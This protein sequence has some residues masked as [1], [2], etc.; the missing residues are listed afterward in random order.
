[1]LSKKE[2]KRRQFLAMT[3]ALGAGAALAACAP[4]EEV[5]AEPTEAPAETGATEPEGETG[6]YPPGLEGFEP[7]AES[8][9]SLPLDHERGTLISQEEWYEMLGEPPEEIEAAF[10]KAG[11]GHAWVN[12][13][14]SMLEGEHEGAN[15]NVWGDPRIWET[16]QP[17]LIEGDIPDVGRQWITGGEQAQIDGV[18]DNIY[19]PVDIL[20]DVEA[21]EAPGK[22]LE[23][24]LAEGGLDGASMGLE[25]AQWALPL[26]QNANAI[27]YNID[28][29]EEHGW[30]RPDELTWEEFMELGEEIKEA[31][32]SPWTY[33]GK[34]P[35]YMNTVLNALIYHK[36]GPQGVCDIDNL[37]EGAWKD[38]G[39]IWAMEQVQ[40]M[41][42]NDWVYPGAEAMTHTEG[43][44]IFFDGKA[45]MVPCGTWLE[46]EMAG[47]TPEDFRFAASA[48]P[49]PEDTKGFPKAMDVSPGGAALVVGNG[50]HPLWGMEFLRFVLSAPT[51]KFMAEELGTMLSIKDPLVEAEEVSEALQSAVDCIEAAE[52]HYIKFWYGAWYADVSKVLDDNYGDFLWSSITVEELTDMLERAAREAREDPD[53]E[54]HERTDCS[55]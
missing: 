4:K 31:D 39:V 21:W 22:R 28:M 14:A 33:Q 47:T 27:W 40:R 41:F 6:V 36:A 18:R 50:K 35:G 10:W 48:V 19:A 44:Q 13:V 9:Q 55:A 51:G 12:F 30:S 42:S 34:Y 32:I 23:E 16:L 2:M 38:P 37:V 46:N 20:L 26:M 7:R 8:L 53:V 15:V 54:K 25:D 17:R 24:V 5:E 43:Q 45:A 1:M 3:L 49:A 29:F 52:G 11:Y